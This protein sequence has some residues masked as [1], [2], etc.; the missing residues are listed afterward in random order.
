MIRRRKE[1]KD[2]S[3]S[4]SVSFDRDNIAFTDNNLHIANEGGR[5]NPPIA[6]MPEAPRQLPPVPVSPQDQG[7][8]AIGGCNLGLSESCVVGVPKRFKPGRAEPNTY[9]D[10]RTLSQ[11][12]TVD[13][14]LPEEEAPTPEESHYSTLDEV[15]SYDIV[16]DGNSPEYSVPRSFDYELPRNVTAQMESFQ[17]QTSSGAMNP[18]YTSMPS[19]I[20]CSVDEIIPPARLQT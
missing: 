19:N 12:T 10:I 17:R 18:L 8:G 1:S 9:A 3:R 13:P 16:K 20:P 14:D 11:A 6:R 15:N 5:S 2:L 7:Q 4:T